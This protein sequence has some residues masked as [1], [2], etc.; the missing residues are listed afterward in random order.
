[1]LRLLAAAAFAAAVTAAGVAAGA[2]PD[3]LDSLRQTALQ[4]VN[5]DRQAAGL[6]PTA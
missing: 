4:A 1:M 5:E 6:C 2:A 3:N